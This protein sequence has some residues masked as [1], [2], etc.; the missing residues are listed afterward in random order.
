MEQTDFLHAGTILHKNGVT[1]VK[2]GSDYSCDGTLKL[3][4][5]EM[6]L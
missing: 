3:T 6:G 5:F 4:V 1:M 2:N